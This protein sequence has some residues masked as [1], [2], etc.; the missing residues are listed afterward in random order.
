MAG[1]LLDYGLTGTVINAINR[2]TMSAYLL[3]GMKIISGNQFVGG[4]FDNEYP[5][6]MKSVKRSF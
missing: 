5:T 4:V 6:L 3:S 1:Y 2:R